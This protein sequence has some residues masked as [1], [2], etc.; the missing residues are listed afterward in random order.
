MVLSLAQ[1]ELRYGPNQ[2]QE[3][4]Q[5]IRVGDLTPIMELYEEEIKHPVK[6]AL[7]GRLLRSIFIQVQKAKVVMIAIRT[8]PFC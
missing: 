4:S 6:S 7:L 2:L 3:L 8:M 5:K 1:D